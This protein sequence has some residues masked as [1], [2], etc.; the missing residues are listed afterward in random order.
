MFFCTYATHL[1]ALCHHHHPPTCLPS[2]HH[3]TSSSVF[4]WSGY[5]Q[6]GLGRVGVF[7]YILAFRKDSNGRLIFRLGA[8]GI[9][10]GR[11]GSNF[12]RY[13]QINPSSL[14]WIFSVQLRVDKFS[15][16]SKFR[17]VP[18]RSFCRL[19][20]LSGSVFPSERVLEFSS[21]YADL[22]LFSV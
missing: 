4:G 19:R 2:C 11:K 8:F 20:V 16:L 12:I 10:F 21:L 18:L 14:V 3:I 9:G 15:S 22:R 6:V 7:L 13:T 17:F 1:A 5:G